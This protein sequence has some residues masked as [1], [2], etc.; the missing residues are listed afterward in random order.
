V[1]TL[2]VII[3]AFNRERS[4]TATIESV[5][6]CGNDAEII[7]VDDGST[8]GT[9]E[10]VRSFGSRVK[11]IEQSNAGPAT[12]RNNGFT[13]SS[14]DVVAFLDSD[15][16]WLPGVVP[17]CLLAM[18]DRPEIDVLFCDTLFGNETNGYR[19]LGSL[20]GHGR[21]EPL[22][23]NRLGPNLFALDRDAFV[24][25]MIHRNQVFLGSS[26]FRRKTLLDGGTFVPSLF[27]GEDYELCLRYAA[28]HKFA[29]F[30][31]P[32]AQYEKHSGGLSSN[33]DRMAR[34]FALAVLKFT[35]SAAIKPM[36]RRRAFA[37]YRALA[38][39]YGYRAYERGEYR[40]A[41]AR[42][43]AALRNGGFSPKSAA[44]YLACC[45]PG[46][47]LRTCRRIWQG[48]QR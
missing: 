43:S 26:L 41:R 33:V 27:G 35:S 19:A 14:G 34:E 12:A 16:V 40:E 48:L 22:L 31:R 5:R 1:L 9:V 37:K 18:N 24:D 10:L 7:V 13:N 3:P 15:D 20:P 32:L 42:F 44:F 23:T 28:T 46:P 45:L 11:L 29:F 2:S 39:G 30:S 21:L 8:D 6:A 38:F 25:A 36:E 17:D 4:I 47:V